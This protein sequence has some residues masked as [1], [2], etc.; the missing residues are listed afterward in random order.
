M[1]RQIVMWAA[2][3]PSRRASNASLRTSARR[4]AILFAVVGS[5]SGCMVTAVRPSNQT[6]SR[7]STGRTVSAAD[8]SRDG[9]NDML[10]AALRRVRPEFLLERGSGPLAVSIDGGSLAEL[11]ILETVRVSMIEDVT[12]ERGALSVGP[13]VMTTGGVVVGV[14]VL[15]VRTRRGAPR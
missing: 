12:L 8:L 3:Q 10:L 9:Q 4:V 5:A 7:Y 11:S 14:D 13:R 2:R 15:L 1:S 6:G